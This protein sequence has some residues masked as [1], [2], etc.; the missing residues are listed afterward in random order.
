MHSTRTLAKAVD[1]AVREAR[2]AFLADPQAQQDAADQGDRMRHIM[3]AEQAAG[4]HA[5][6]LPVALAELLVRHLRR[7]AEG[8]PINPEMAAKML[9]DHLRK[10]A[11]RGA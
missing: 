8:A 6:V 5:V 4:A 9:E 7:E 1:Q 10:A 2:A 11:E 3:D